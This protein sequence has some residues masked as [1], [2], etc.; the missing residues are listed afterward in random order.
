M[1]LPA[2]LFLL[3]T[4]LAAVQVAT[5]GQALGDEKG[6]GR[7]TINSG[8]EKHEFRVEIAR[9]ERQQS[10]GL[11]YRRQLP[12]DAGML[13]V[14]KPP[15]RAAMWMKN[16]F[17]PLDML[18]IGNGNRIVKIAERTMPLSHKI[19]SSPV[20]VRGVLEVNAGTASRLGIRTGDRVVSVALE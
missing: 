3:W 17:I 5:G 4:V 11:M 10:R 14:Y 1:K 20:P 2:K 19:I 9:T 15:V 18:F 12:A 7:L 6:H 8:D 13:F 16:T